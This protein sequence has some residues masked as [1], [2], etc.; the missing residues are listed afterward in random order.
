MSISIS[1]YKLTITK[2][3]EGFPSANSILYVGFNTD[4]SCFVVSTDTGF[5]VFNTQPVT[6]RFQRGII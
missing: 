4:S 6:F 3:V 2:M 5:R 1:I